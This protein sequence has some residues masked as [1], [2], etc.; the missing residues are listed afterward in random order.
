MN[1]PG[2]VLGD[3]GRKLVLIIGDFNIDTKPFVERGLLVEKVKIEDAKKSFLMAKAI[4]V[5]D[6]PSKFRLIK[7]SFDEIFADADDYGITKIV[8][9]HNHEDLIK[10][11]WTLT[12]SAKA[13]LELTSNLTAVSE[14]IARYSPGPPAIDME[15][16]C[17]G[18]V[19]LNDEIKLLLQR[20]FYDCEKIHVH[21]I[22]GGQA[23]LNLF[24]IYPWV[25][26]SNVGPSPSPYFAKIA[27]HRE[28]K[29]EK[30][31]YQLYS[32]N[33][34]P[35]HYRPNC[36]LERC[37]STR[38][39][40]SLVGDFVDEAIPLRFALRDVHYSGIIFSLFEKTLK[41]FR[42]QPYVAR[43]GSMR[44]VLPNFA[45]ERV[46]LH[47]LISKV[48]VIN[49]AVNLG[50]KSSPEKMLDGLV[51][52]CPTTC[53][54]GPYHGDLHFGNVM[55][56]GDDAI[57]IDFFS[58]KGSAPLTADPAT[59][60]ISLCFKFD[61]DE[62]VDFDT[63]KDFIDEA[64]DPIQLL[65]PLALS[66]HIPNEVSWLRRA[67]REIRHILR[68]CECCDEEIQVMVATYLMRIARLADMD[69]L[70]TEFRCRAYA[71]VVA[72]RIIN[73]LNTKTAVANESTGNKVNA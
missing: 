69:V 64:Y 2:L 63:W 33:Y 24:K 71:L 61:K 27:G 13:Q 25:G 29:Q 31:N 43:T 20:S 51:N 68:G 19:V 18:E 11:G 6:F 60:E 39:Y 14:K 45:K 17:H 26:K 10:L 62:K 8:L 42:S 66:E 44:D 48:D 40:S 23:S 1:N 41:G 32:D 37:V 7:R 55:V 54:T 30:N 38:N 9:V 52:A 47:E 72:E 5:A 4:I 34:I 58:V 36:R 28:I 16:T 67:I 35:F 57:L 73:H 46:K 70:S 21:S 12:Q 15:V 56:K 50:L 65:K 3:F 59:L 49:E 22:G 53:M